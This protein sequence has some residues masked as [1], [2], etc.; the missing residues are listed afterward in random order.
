MTRFPVLGH[1][2]P[3]LKHPFLLQNIVYCFRMSFSCFRMSFSA[4]SC[5]VLRPIP[6]FDYP[7]PSCPEFWLSRP[8]PSL[9]KIFSLSRCP[10][11]PGQRPGQRDKLKI[12]SRD[13]TGQDSQNSGWDGLGQPKTGTKRD[14]AKKDILKQENDILKQKMM[15]YNRKGC[16]KTGK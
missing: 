2:F 11:V 4:L 16:S 6:D 13:G 3:D 14:R 9:G 5:F 7:G 8:V 12:L 10:F 1:H 15:F